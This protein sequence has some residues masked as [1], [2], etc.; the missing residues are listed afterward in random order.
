MT[1]L[2]VRVSVTFTTTRIQKKTWTSSIQPL[3]PE[4]LAL[5]FFVGNLSLK[6]IRLRGPRKREGLEGNN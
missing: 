4:H 2:D 6:W 5:F 3:P 1:F